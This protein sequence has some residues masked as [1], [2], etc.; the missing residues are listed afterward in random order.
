MYIT[1]FSQ[2]EGLSILLLFS[3]TYLAVME[4]RYLFLFAEKQQ[5]MCFY[6]N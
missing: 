1:H 6:S 5:K 3:V 2:N 4:M